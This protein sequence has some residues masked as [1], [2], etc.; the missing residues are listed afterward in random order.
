MLRRINFDPEFDEKLKKT[1]IEYIFYTFEYN[2]YTMLEELI[3]SRTR[4]KILTLFFSNPEN[5]FYIRELSRKIDEN[6]NSVRREL[7][8]LEE[9]GLLD[10]EREGNLKYYLIN[11]KIPIYEE[12]KNIFL[13]TEGVGALIREN[14]GDL[15]NIKKAFIYGSFARGEEKLKS[16]I[17]LMIIG[18]ADQEKLSL[19]VRKLEAR[20]SREINYVVFTEKEFKERKERNDSFI[21]NILKEKRI[22]II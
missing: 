13:K 6:I 16:D 19:L 7:R 5:R 21:M 9:I 20:I 15:G 1:D 4:V 17:D 3:T 2:N 14:L 11:K 22:E 12:L 10:S 18:E 8:K